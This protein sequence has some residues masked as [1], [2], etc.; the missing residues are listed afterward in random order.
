MFGAV[1]PRQT[2]DRTS[3]AKVP[4]KKMNYILSW[5]P[6]DFFYYD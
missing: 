4:V 1:S 5:D 2:Y 6:L 3:G